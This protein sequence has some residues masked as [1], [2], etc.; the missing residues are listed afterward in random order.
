[1]VLLHQPLLEL[2]SP[3]AIAEQKSHF[4]SFTESLCKSLSSAALFL[5]TEKMRAFDSSVS[6]EGSQGGLT[7]VVE[8]TLIK[9]LCQGSLL[10][11]HTHLKENIGYL[12]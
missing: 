11:G 9:H 12:T 5:S 6:K 10:Y 1:M 3:H 2:S 8:A 7:N 4:W